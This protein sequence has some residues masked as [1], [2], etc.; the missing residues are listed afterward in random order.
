MR[1]FKALC[2]LLQRQTYSCLSTRSGIWF[3]LG[4]L[5]LLGISALQFSEVLL[6]WSMQKYNIAF[7]ADHDNIAGRSFQPRLCL[8]GPID[9]VYTWVNGSDP[10]LIE[11]LNKVK[12]SL[13][14]QLNLTS[15]GK[16]DEAEVKSERTSKKV[17]SSG[18]SRSNSEEKFKWKS[19]DVCPF[20][21]CIPY[22]AIAVSG[23]QANTSEFALFVENKFLPGFQFSSFGSS[24]DPSVKVL[25]F[26]KDFNFENLRNHT[27]T[28]KGKERR[29]TR[30]FVSSTLRMGAQKLDGIGMI[31]YVPKDITVKMIENGLHNEKLNAASIIISNNV[32]VIELD[33]KFKTKYLNGPFRGRIT[34]NDQNFKV[35]P[36]TFVWKP[37]TPLEIGRDIIE[38][39]VS[40]SRFADNEELKYSL[41]SV[42]KYAPWVRNIYIVTNGQIPSW[43]NLDHP[44]MKIVTHEELFVNKSHLP[45]FS[46]PAIETH[47]HRIPGLS[48]RFIYMNDDVFFGDYVWPDDFYTH[49]KG[50]KIYLTWPVPNCNEGCPASW[51]NDK[52]CDKPCNVSEC[53]WDGGDCL[54][55]NGKTGFPGHAIT[56]FHGNAYSAI[57]EYCNGGCANSWI[58]DRYCDANCNVPNCGYDAGDCG[59]QKFKELFSVNA[60]KIKG[61]LKVPD[62]VRAFYINFTGLLNDGVL[63]DG[64]YVESSVIRAAIFSKKFKTMSV[65]LYV[66]FTSTVSFAVVGFKDKNQT[67]PINLNFTISVDTTKEQLPTTTRNPATKLVTNSGNRLK[68]LREPFTV[69]N[70]ASKRI[71]KS[72]PRMR[73]KNKTMNDVFD[74]FKATEREIPLEII[75]ELNKTENELNVG[76]ITENGYSHRKFQ[77]IRPFYESSRK[78]PAEL[79]GNKVCLFV[80]IMA[81]II[82]IVYRIYILVQ[83]RNSIIIVSSRQTFKG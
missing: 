53:D 79:E 82:K 78:E 30:V 29:Y 32:S 19:E 21:N 61:T 16:H 58:G 31:N 63:T 80:I 45:T 36:A 37:L 35:L 67:I 4:G 81:L 25:V 8:P 57:G 24:I 6:E 2:K 7:S 42:E 15:A 60:E 5:I 13:M 59:I 47:I 49:T 17:K 52:Y 43:L 64:D 51:V 75:S 55:T 34:I 39:D 38:E 68:S 27:I 66:N 14:L 33:S 10:Q 3:C 83:Q 72:D 74:W 18:K 50:Q 12:E 69:Y 9:I 48:K 73:Y 62:G 70:E 77:I 20:P 44:R 46:S 65:T 1:P 22:N 76:D 56:N 71:E 11:E 28:L 54:N 40:S 41:R 23:L 26:G